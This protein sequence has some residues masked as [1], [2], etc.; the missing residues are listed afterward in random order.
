[1]PYIFPFCKRWK[2]IFEKSFQKSA[3]GEI[4][5]F[6]DVQKELMNDTPP[7]TKPDHPPLRKER[8]K[9]RGIIFS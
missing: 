8:G 7:T 4:F 6:H 1:L 5:V 3:Q 9:K 2:T